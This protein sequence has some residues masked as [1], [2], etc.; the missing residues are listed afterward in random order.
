MAMPRARRK[1]GLRKLA[2]TVPI[3]HNRKALR[4]AAVPKDS[5][6][7]NY[8]RDDAGGF[9]GRLADSLTA[10]FGPGRVFRDVTGIDYGD[11][12]ER[13]IDEKLA[14]SGALVVV[15]GERWASVTKP[16]GTRRL[17]DPGDYVIRE[18]GSALRG[19]IP[20]VPVLIGKASMPRPDE[21]PAG[22]AE[23]CRH[24]AMTVTDERWEFDVAR[25]AKVLAIDVPGS[26]AQRRL[27]RLKWLALGLLIASGL[28]ATLAFCLTLRGTAPPPASL[29][30]AGFAPIVSAI[31]F[32]AIVVAAAATLNALPLMEEPKRKFGW[33]AVGLAAAGTLG[34]FIH[35]ALMNVTAP[36]WSLIVNFGASTLLT[37]ALL[38]LIGLAGFRAK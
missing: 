22:L 15:I 35:Y 1:F 2:L 16:D 37:F 4:E 20:V 14:E 17:D 25:L 23:L 29:R 38:A 9:A 7:I 27:D 32:I 24:N 18:I 3:A 6:F 5:I 30:A 10:Y 21:L 34:A 31:P 13:V 19:T 33:I 11:D 12:F 26:V 8:R 36:S 28:I